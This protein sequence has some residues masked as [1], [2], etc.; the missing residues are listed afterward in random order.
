MTGREGKKNSKILICERFLWTLARLVAQEL[1]E[2]KFITFK[3]KK[4]YSEKLCRKI[5]KSSK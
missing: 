5:Y 3:K 4:H 2:V 1:F